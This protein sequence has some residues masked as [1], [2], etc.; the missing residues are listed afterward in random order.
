MSYA[1]NESSPDLARVLQSL[2]ALEYQSGRLDEYLAGIAESV[3]GL[4]GI[5]WSVVTLSGD[6][7]G[8]RILASSMEPGDSAGGDFSLHGSVAERVMESSQPLCIVDADAS[9][10]LGNMPEGYRSYIGVPLRTSDGRTIGTVCSF[11]RRPKHF[12]PQQ[13]QLASL[14]AERAAAA[15]ER[16]NAFRRLEIFNDRLEDLVEERTRELQQTQ[17][18]LVERERLA[19]IGQ[20]ASMITHEIRSPLSTIAMALDYARGNELPDGMR[21][22]IHLASEESGRLQQLLDE[23][24]MFAKPQ[25][26]QRERLDLD[27]LSL[28]TIERF[29]VAADVSARQID[30][31]CD[32]T[33]VSVD[34]DAD[35]LGQVII[36][37]LSNACQATRPDQTVSVQ[38]D[39]AADGSALMLSVC[40]PGCIGEQDLARLTEPFFT[41]RAQGTGLGLA[42]VQRIVDAHGGRLQILSNDQVRVLVTLPSV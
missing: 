28:A 7:D 19:A 5:D 26:L 17:A 27:A 37:L 20:F 32:A 6:G 10:D 2:G 3:S 31:R 41:T 18:Q 15:I 8:D 21:K 35:K 22:R 24:L 13:V 1:V 36:N 12:S 38:L 42:I 40:N 25:Q 14:F 23:I 33:R 11:H 4:L 34:G 29:R 39:D 9:P 30:Y 16:F